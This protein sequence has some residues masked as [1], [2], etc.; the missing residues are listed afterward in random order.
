MYE[1][2]SN[3]FFTPS[4]D[5]KTETEEIKDISEEEEEEINIELE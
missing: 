1:N 5:Q 2:G 3:G 4:L